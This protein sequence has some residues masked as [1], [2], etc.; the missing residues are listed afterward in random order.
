[1]ANQSI[2]ISITE[3]EFDAKLN[4]AVSLA[5]EKALNSLKPHTIEP[6]F[7]SRKEAA[8]KLNVTLP[9]LHIWTQ[10]GKITGHRVGSRVLYKEEDLTNALQKIHTTIRAAA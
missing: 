1:M 5:I 9:T 6:R 2:L 10:E 3:A 4:G 8:R 7:Y